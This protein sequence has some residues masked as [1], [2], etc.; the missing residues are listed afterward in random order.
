[1]ERLVAVDVPE[2][3]HEVLVRLEPDGAV[4]VLDDDLRLSNGLAWRPDGRELYSVDTLPGVVWAR[5]YDPQGGG[6]GPRREL[7]RI[8]GG[9]SPD[10]LTVDVDGNLR[11]ALYGAGEVRRYT[12]SG[13]LTG[14][15]EVAAPHPTCPAFV[16]PDLDLLLISTAT[17]N[18]DEEQLGRYPRSGNLF[19]VRVGVR[20]LPA[21]PWQV[22]PSW[23]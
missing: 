23:G 18:L 15:V 20:G 6:I 7:L 14:V 22:P 9:G 10:V 3:G 4:T 19:A 2:A 5:S 17:E 8:T 11:I 16:G 13:E 1:V 12:P 21:T